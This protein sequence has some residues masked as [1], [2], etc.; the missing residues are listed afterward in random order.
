MN[1]RRTLLAAVLVALLG[2]CVPAS[3]T[4]QRQANRADLQFVEA[5]NTCIREVSWFGLIPD[6][7]ITREGHMFKCMQEAGW[8]QTPRFNPDAIGRYHRIEE[9]GPCHTFWCQETAR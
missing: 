7:G 2:G 6:W 3:V 1:A 9:P 4:L 8:V 5:Y